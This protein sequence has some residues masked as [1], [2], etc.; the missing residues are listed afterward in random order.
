MFLL[1]IFFLAISVRSEK[2]CTPDNYKIVDVSDCADNKRVLSYGLKSA[3]CLGAATLTSTQSCDC[4][5]SEY[6]PTVSPCDAATWT[7]RLTGWEGT[8]HRGGC[9]ADPAVQAALR[10]SVTPTSY[11]PCECTAADVGSLYTP[12]DAATASRHVVF[13][14]K[15]ECTRGNMTLPMS[16]RIGCRDECDDGQY[17]GPPNTQCTNCT[18]GT[19]SVPGSVYMAPWRKWPSNFHT[20]CNGVEGN[21][22]SCDAWRLRGEVIDSGHQNQTASTVSTL[23]VWADIVTAPAVLT[24]TFRTSS[25]MYGDYFW[26]DAS[27]V[28]HLIYLCN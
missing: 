15:R 26:V 10:G 6:V 12:C 3:T 2:A 16:A 9:R 23:M 18:P 22:G 11:I 28:V 4:Q 8:V 21:G 19:F 25:E 1:L 7:R 24:V 5:L 14:W 13:F 27:E 20:V 17:F